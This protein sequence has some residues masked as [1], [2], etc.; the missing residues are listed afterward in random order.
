MKKYYRVYAVE[1]DVLTPIAGGQFTHE[2]AAND[3]VENNTIH[4]TLTVLSVWEKEA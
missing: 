1:N 3:F 2:G 4:D